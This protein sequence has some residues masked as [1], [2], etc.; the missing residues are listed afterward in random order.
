MRT[1]IITGI[2]PMES[3]QL[4]QQFGLPRVKGIL[5]QLTAIERPM[6]GSE[7]G[8]HSPFVSRTLF[9]RRLGNFAHDE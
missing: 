4:L 3:I 8:H 1:G 9:L 2:L 5:G 7:F 6:Q